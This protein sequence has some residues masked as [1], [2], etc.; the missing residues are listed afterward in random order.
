MVKIWYNV[1]KRIVAGADLRWST[2]ARRN[3]LAR[4]RALFLSCTIRT[5]NHCNLSFG[6]SER[7]TCLIDL[8]RDKLRNRLNG[9]SDGLRQDK[10]N[11][12]VADCLT[13]WVTECITDLSGPFLRYRWNLSTRHA[14][15]VNG[16]MDGLVVIFTPF[17]FPYFSM[18]TS[19]MCWFQKILKSYTYTF[20]NKNKAF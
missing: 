11:S 4:L 12:C 3:T 16:L 8:I 2:R 14:S 5:T 17:D 9:R 1:R 18:I 15:C 19:T 20:F 13:D 7:F 10:G 6:L